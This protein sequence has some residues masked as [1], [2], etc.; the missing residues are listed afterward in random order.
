MYFKY[1][2]FGKNN[3]KIDLYISDSSTLF[4]NQIITHRKFNPNFRVSNSSYL[5]IKNLSYPEGDIADLNYVISDDSEYV[6]KTPKA[7]IQPI[8]NENNALEELNNLVGLDKVK[9]E[10]K[11]MVRM[12]DFNK[13]R[14]EKGTTT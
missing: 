8:D 12:V 11:K 10:I 2:F 7:Q 5:Q 4:A 9:Q 6:L 14:V 3:G 1:R 13:K